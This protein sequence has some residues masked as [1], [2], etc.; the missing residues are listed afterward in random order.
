MYKT[1]IDKHR[2]ATYEE[3]LQAA[4]VVNQSGLFLTTE[5]AGRLSDSVDRFLLHYN[6]LTHHAFAAG[7]PRY[8]I[9][10]KFHA[11]IHIAAF[12]VFQS[13]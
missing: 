11:L 13:P 4:A 12:G 6:V 8:N 1:T 9:V 3:L 7:T 5:Q 2:I 10:P